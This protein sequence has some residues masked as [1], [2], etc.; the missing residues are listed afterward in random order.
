ME[1][2]E[3]VSTVLSQIADGVI[4]A[5]E[6]TAGKG[7]LI[8]PPL[9]PKNGNN[10]VNN[11]NKVNF[12][13]QMVHFDVCVTAESSSSIDGKGEIR[14]AVFGGMAGK[15]QSNHKDTHVSRISFSLPVCWTSAY[16]KEQEK[17]PTGKVSLVQRSIPDRY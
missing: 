9:Y 8:N 2:R 4:D 7:V 11:G 6:A 15:A 1:L 3:F 17:I 16:E 14:V 10:E 13:P 12:L 5:Q